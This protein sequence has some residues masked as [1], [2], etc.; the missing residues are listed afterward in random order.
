MLITGIFDDNVTKNYP[1]LCNSSLELE[2][3]MYV[4]HY[5]RSTLAVFREMG[6]N[7][8]RMFP[9]VE[10]LLKIL[11]TSPASLCEAERSFST[12]RRL[13]TWLRSTMTQTRLNHVAVCHV[14]RDILMKLC[15]QDIAREFVRGS[16]AR[17]RVFGKF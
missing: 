3:K 17:C 9:A 13:K 14:Y 16:D 6:P 1:R 8:R 2:L 5:K 12:L 10:M 7:V 4:R 15:C 11:L